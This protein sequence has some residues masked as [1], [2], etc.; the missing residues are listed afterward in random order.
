MALPIRSIGG[1]SIVYIGE[2]GGSDYVPDRQATGTWEAFR[3]GLNDRYESLDHWQAG[4]SNVMLERLLGKPGWNRIYDPPE[5]E[6]RIQSKS[7]IYP[8]TWDFEKI[9]PGEKFPWEL[10][11]E[12]NEEIEKVL[13][14]QIQNI[15][16]NITW[17]MRNEGLSKDQAVEKLNEY[18]GLDAKFG[19]L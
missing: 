6:I 12:N 10:W 18:Q 8:M 19:L 2:L 5:N 14:K 13:N 4:P 9:N 17:L 3:L 11:L 7:G 1:K 15:Q 16:E